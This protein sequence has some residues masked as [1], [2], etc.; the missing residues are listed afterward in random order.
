M[1]NDVTTGT[2]YTYTHGAIRENN[3]KR[4]EYIDI[5]RGIAIILMILGHVC[6]V[7]WK[8]TII[9]SFHMPLFIIISGMFFK[10]EENIK[11]ELIKLFRKLI[12]PYVI[13]IITTELIKIC[14]YN[15]TIDMVRVFQ[16]IIF[17]YSN[18]KTFFTEINSVGVL[19]F[20][21]FLSLCKI[22]FYAIHKVAKEDDML[23]GIICLL[24]TIIGIYF[25]K[26]KLYLPW[27]FDIVLASLIFYY[28]GYILKKY[29]VLEKILS[30]YKILICIVLLYA[31]GLKFGFIELAIRSYPHGFICYVTAISGTIIVFKISQIIEK[32]SKYITKVLSWFGRNSM[33]VLCFHYLEMNVIKYSYFGITSKWQLA[34]T[35]VIIITIFTKMIE[36]IKERKNAKI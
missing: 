8:R 22:L 34:I 12:I 28:I 14:I 18:K 13:T 36:I 35:K 21:P 29:K 9:F 1:E 16:Q 2:V 10:K 31:I 24:F 27:S 6:K 11:E 23:K 15:E 17:A 5:A 19:W 32:F 30:N 3:K 20:I 33:Y 7:G 25:S 4:L 26:T